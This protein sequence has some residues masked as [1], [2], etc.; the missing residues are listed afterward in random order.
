MQSTSVT[1]LAIRFASTSCRP[2]VFP[3]PWLM[4]TSMVVVLMRVLVVVLI[5][6]AIF[7]LLI[8]VIVLRT[9]AASSVT[10]LLVPLAARNQLIV[11]MAM[12]ALLILVSTLFAATRLV[13]AAVV[14]RVIVLLRF[15]RLLLVLTTRASTALLATAVDLTLNVTMEMVV[16][17]MFAPTINV[18]KLLCL[19]LTVISVP[20]LSLST[21]ME[22]FAVPRFA[23]LHPTK[24]PTLLVGA[25]TVVIMFSDPLTG[26]VLLTGEISEALGVCHASCDHAELVAARALSAAGS[27]CVHES[28]CN[29][30]NDCTLDSCNPSTYTCTY[31]RLTTGGCSRGDDRDQYRGT[32]ACSCRNGF[33]CWY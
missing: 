15:A 2:V 5:L 22:V 18:F 1:L 31:A 21:L 19:M 9:S 16:L 30:G 32:S 10:V 12:H 20:Q 4:L 25:V 11:M 14:F 26:A 23:G 3:I 8:C 28:D 27:C 33:C 17:V 13:L 7:A 29:D 24:F 6:I